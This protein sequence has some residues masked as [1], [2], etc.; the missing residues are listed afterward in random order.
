LAMFHP[1]YAFDDENTKF[2]FHR[3]WPK[4]E[5]VVILKQMFD[6]FFYNLLNL[7]VFRAWFMD[8]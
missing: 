3:R 1:T 6:S 4:V 2:N 5:N 7:Y 8:R